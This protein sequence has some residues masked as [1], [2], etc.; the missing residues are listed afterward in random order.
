[1]MDVESS[2]GELLSP[3]NTFRSLNLGEEGRAF[4]IP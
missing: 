1:V 2:R 4:D 3:L